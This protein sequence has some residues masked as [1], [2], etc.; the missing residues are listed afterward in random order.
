[1]KERNKTETGGRIP[2]TGKLSM[3]CPVQADSHA[4]WR[5]FNLLANFICHCGLGIVILLYPAR[6][7]I[8]C[9]KQRWVFCYVM[10][11]NKN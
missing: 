10:A 4:N 9:S 11:D 8:V 6:L 7:L 3:L 2:V 1:M 5:I